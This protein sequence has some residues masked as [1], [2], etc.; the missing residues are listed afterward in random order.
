MLSS[1]IVSFSVTASSEQNMEKFSV[2]DGFDLHT[3]LIRR[4]LEGFDFKTENP[5]LILG[6]GHIEDPSKL[7]VYTPGTNDELSTSHLDG[8]LDFHRNKGFYTASAEKDPAFNSDWV[9]NFLVKPHRA[10]LFKDR[11]FG[12]IFDATYSPSAFSSD[13]FKDIADSLMSGGTYIMQLPLAQVSDSFQSAHR[14]NSHSMPW[15][16]RE[17]SFPTIVS[18]E[19][20]WRNFLLSQGF[21]SVTLEEAPVSFAFKERGLSSLKI[22]EYLKD[23]SLSQV[24]P[25]LFNK[26][27][28]KYSE[29]SKLY[30]LCPDLRHYPLCNY[31]LMAK[32]D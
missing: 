25:D 29:S 31:Y 16:S 4:S 32:K 27:L 14:I 8:S 23:S 21:T 13:I 22:H 2:Q 19:T 11:F 5:I 15:F 17:L 9:G 18:V 10:T 12:I 1:F 28:F 20:H 30:Q 7:S 24:N 3:P 26:S 6:E